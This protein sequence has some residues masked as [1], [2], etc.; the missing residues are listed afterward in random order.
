MSTSKFRADEPKRSSD[1]GSP[2][3]SAPAALRNRQAIVDAI[4]D[5]LPK[6]GNVLELASGTGEHICFFAQRFDQLSWQ[7]SEMDSSRLDSIRAYS[8]ATALPNL[9]EPVFLDVSEASWHTREADVI[10]AI[11]LLHVAPKSVS[12]AVLTGAAKVLKPSGILILYGPFMLNAAFNSESNRLFDLYL[13]D[14]N[15]A[16]GLRD[17]A[18]LDEVAGDVGLT[19]DALLDM[20]ANNFLAAYRKSTSTAP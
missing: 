9:S 18:D 13:R 6:R 10:L 12:S 2:E 14:Q 4:G 7:P 8:A 19:R 1:S 17:I 15:P 3:I 5:L 20:P 16:W 11:N